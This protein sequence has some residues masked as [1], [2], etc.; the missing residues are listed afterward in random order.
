MNEDTTDYIIL[1]VRNPAFEV[2]VQLMV[3]TILGAGGTSPSMTM[4][5]KDGPEIPDSDPI[6]FEQIPYLGID[7]QVG[8]KEGSPGRIMFHF[9][10]PD[11]YNAADLV[12]FLETGMNNPKPPISVESIRSAYKILWIDDGVDGEGNPIG[13]YEYEVTV[14]AK[15]AKF[16]PYMTEDDEGTTNEFLSGYFSSD[17]IE[18]V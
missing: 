5:Y 1:S 6:A 10:L 4:H 13:H 17:P 2:N 14:Q 9:R 3:E 11:F 7:P 8:T 16:L 15:R 12:T 18:L